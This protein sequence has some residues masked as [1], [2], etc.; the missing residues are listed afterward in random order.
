LHELVVGLYHRPGR[1]LASGG[2]HLVSWLMGGIE[3]MVALRVVGVEVDL[4]QGLL[5]ESIGQA[6][7]TVGF[8]IPG[9]LGVQEGGYI[10]ICGLVGVEPQS[11][12]ELSLLK[13]V[14]EMVL[15]VPGLVMWQILE[16]RR[17]AGRSTSSA[18][19]V[20]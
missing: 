13:R 5:I 20:P 2:Y 16:G 17:L 10:L 18:K 6:M 11:A 15:G 19:V 4:A 12:I 14:R 1:L 8:A 3:V 7:R 9:S